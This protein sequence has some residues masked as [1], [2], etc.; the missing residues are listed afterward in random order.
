VLDLVLLEL[1]DCRLRLS[2][3]VEGEMTPSEAEFITL[4]HVKPP[5]TTLQPRYFCP[6]VAMVTKTLQKTKEVIFVKLRHGSSKMN[7]S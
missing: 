5:S 1:F 6:M 7:N 2:V 3:Q 4:S